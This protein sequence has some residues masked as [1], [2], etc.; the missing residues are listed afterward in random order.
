MAAAGIVQ[1][2]DDKL[3]QVA[4]PFNL[5]TEEVR[6]REVVARLRAALDRIGELHTFGKGV[7]LAA[8][9]LGLGWSAAVVQPPEEDVE[10]VI[11]L[12]PRV[13]GSSAETDEQYEGCLSFFDVRGL[14]PRARHLEVEHHL[15]DGRQVVSV[16]TDGV[17]RLVAHEIDHLDGWLYRDRM[18]PDAALVPVDRY[19]QAGIG[20][21]YPRPSTVDSAERRGDGTAGGSSYAA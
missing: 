18:R 15:P 17:A 8:P 13:V 10:A 21:S 2:G 4:R 1:R 11:L 20:W 6:A 7:G 3:R 5:P 9:Q 14:V 19:A 12:N 16:F